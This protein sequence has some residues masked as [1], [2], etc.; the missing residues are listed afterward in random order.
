[1]PAHRQFVLSHTRAPGDIVCMTPL[2]RDIYL[3]YGNKYKIDVDTTCKDLWR[4]NPY[5]TSLYDHEQKRTKYPGVQYV[6]L[7][8]GAGIREQNKETIHFATY[9]HRISNL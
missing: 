2:I 5:L 6:K 4:H 8:Y 3:T 7:N 9:F 1:M